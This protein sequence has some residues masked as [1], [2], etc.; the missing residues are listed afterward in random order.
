MSNTNMYDLS[1]DQCVSLLRAGGHL[2]TVL[3]QGHMGTGKTSLF[4]MLM[5]LLGSTHH[6]CYFDSTTKSQGDVMMPKMKNTPDDQDYVRFATNEELGVHIT[7]RPGVIMLDEIGKAPRSV[8]NSLTR[9]MQ[10][11][12]I[13]SYKLHPDSIVFATTNLGAEGVGDVLPPHVRNRITVINMRKPTHL[14]WIEWGINNGIDPIMLGWVRDNPQVFADFTEV[15]NPDDNEYIYHPKSQ[16]AAFVTPR[17]LEK[18]SHWLKLRDSLDDQT[19]VAA[20][21]GQIGDRAAMDMMAFV[22]LADQLPRLDQIKTDPMNAPVPTSAAAVVMVVYRSLSAMSPDLANPWMDYMMRLDNEAQGMFANGVR[23]A[24]Y[25][26]QALMMNNRK[27]TD[28]AMKNGYLFAA[29]RV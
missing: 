17:S 4:K 2:N 26:H 11:R 29:D 10:E 5:K 19:V 14:E 16:R 9:L 20:L 22:K 3:F 23:S 1:I 7:S 28:W 25:Q 27:F 21:K 8:Q 6:G 18:A 13:G 12:E 15:K 24:K